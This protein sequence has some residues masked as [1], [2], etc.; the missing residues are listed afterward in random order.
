MTPVPFYQ[1]AGQFGDVWEF[2][3]IA[4]LVDHWLDPYG[5]TGVGLP[6]QP[7]PMETYQPDTCGYLA[8]YAGFGP[9]WPAQAHPLQQQ[10]PTVLTFRSNGWSDNFG[11]GTIDDIA[12]YVRDHGPVV[13]SVPH[14]VISV[15]GYDLRRL[16]G[17][18]PVICYQDS[19][20][21]WDGEPRVW[22]ASDQEFIAHKGG[23]CS[24][25]YHIE[26][27]LAPIAY[28]SDDWPFI[29][30]KIRAA[31]D[32]NADGIPDD[33]SLDSDA[34]RSFN[35]FDCSPR[36]PYQYIDID[37]DDHG[38]PRLSAFQEETCL[39]WCENLELLG[40]IFNQPYGG[41]QGCEDKC[42]D[43][44]RCITTGIKNVGDN[45][46][47][48]RCLSTRGRDLNG[49]DH[50]DPWEICS[51]PPNA[52]VGDC[53]NYMETDLLENQC[54]PLYSNVSNV[55]S[56][57]TN[58]GTTDDDR[59]ADVCETAVSS[60]PMVS[61]DSHGQLIWEP[62]P[63]G[64]ILIPTGFCSTSRVKIEL[65]LLGGSEWLVSDGV[66][67]EV[68]FAFPQLRVSDVGVCGCVGDWSADCIN[69]LVC[70]ETNED[71]FNVPVW[72]NIDSLECADYG[73]G[74]LGSQGIEGK[75]ASHWRDEDCSDGLCNIHFTTGGSAAGQTAH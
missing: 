1:C 57:E 10:T 48:W 47:D 17:S 33:T 41:G 54:L 32:I 74:G 72:E 11:V 26:S 21:G 20:W 7:F 45:Q 46:C 70:T 61:H 42:R 24:S 13:C 14:H 25:I 12:P 69:G 29:Q 64:N 27:V 63:G 60:R 15:V 44:D 51:P 38:E 62:T 68:D 34:D 6:P 35:A 55:D 58:P 18:P 4:G 9:P 19:D 53:C 65:G 71:I 50:I 28:H 59:I 8:R 43:W 23:M 49:D 75:V 22:C 40:A 67:Y 56:D 30:W 37:L 3:D 5:S 66:R 16:Y 2:L 52:H 39:K 73:V 31:W 36:N